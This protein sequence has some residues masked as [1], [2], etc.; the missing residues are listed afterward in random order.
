MIYIDFQG[1]THGNYLE[2]VCNKFL[3]KIKTSLQTPFNTLGASHL[4]NK[5]AE[6]Q[7]LKVFAC[8]H[9]SIYHGV[10]T[11]LKNSKIVSIQLD[12]NDLLNVMSICLLRA[13]DHNIDNNYLEINT[14][15]KLNNYDLREVMDGLENYFENNTVISYNDIK[16]PSWPNITTDREYFQLPDHIKQECETVF[17]IRPRLFSADHPDC[18]RFILREF[19]KITFLDPDK[20]KYI[21]NQEHMVYDDSNQAIVFPY[22]SFYNTDSFLHNLLKVAEFFN[23]DLEVSDELLQLHH[24]FLERQPYKYIKQKCDS[25]FNSVINQQEVQNLKLSLLEEAYLNAK[26]E[27]YFKK[28]APFKQDQWFT[29]SNSILDYFSN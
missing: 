5:N 9:Y 19:F 28:E 16:D 17:D 20:F 21:K 26:F 22:S 24:E 25:I 27:Q 10:K 2:F 29:D 23:F 13:G 18:P 7:K 15:N 12:T 3:A 8:G 1:G 4:K 11:E 6:Y 14:F